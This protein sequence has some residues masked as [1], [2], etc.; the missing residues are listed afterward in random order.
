MSTLLLPNARYHLECGGMES[1]DLG[2]LQGDLAQPRVHLV[3]EGVPQLDG[4][5]LEDEVDVAKADAADEEARQVD[6]GQVAVPS[7]GDLEEGEGGEG[8]EG[9]L[10]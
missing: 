3:L 10:L 1:D 9:A 6:V 8:E 5:A 4:R 2:S 7:H